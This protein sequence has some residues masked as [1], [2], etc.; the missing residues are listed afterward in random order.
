[1][2]PRF[3]G[4]EAAEDDGIFKD[5]RN[6]K[7]DYLWRGDKAFSPMSQIYDMLKKPYEYAREIS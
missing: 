7:H 4:S 2:N 5:N 3:A 1:L 6:P